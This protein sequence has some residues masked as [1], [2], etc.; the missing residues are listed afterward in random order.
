VVEWSLPRTVEDFALFR[1]PVPCIPHHVEI[2]FR[3]LIHPVWNESF[4]LRSFPV[5]QDR[6]NFSD[7]SGSIEGALTW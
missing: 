7:A 3:S 4:T 1:D 6:C 5:M 2:T